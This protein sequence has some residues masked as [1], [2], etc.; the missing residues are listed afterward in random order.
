MRLRTLSKGYFETAIDYY[1]QALAIYPQ[2]ENFWV[3]MGQAYD[4][5]KDFRKAEQAYRTAIDLDP[6]LGVLYAYY[7]AHFN[8]RGRHED[9]ARQLE[10]AHSLAQQNLSA[11]ANST[12]PPPDTDLSQ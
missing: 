7:A 5:L 4:G 9:A 2:D 12:L 1:Q 8:A 6:N 11:L 3:R 10:K